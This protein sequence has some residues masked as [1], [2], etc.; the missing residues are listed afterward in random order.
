MLVTG[1]NF[2]PLRVKGVLHIGPQ[3]RKSCRR[4]LLGLLP[5]VRRTAKARNG[6]PN[7]LNNEKVFTVY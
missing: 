6:P 3:R 7:I 1:M 5:L 4:A 2:H